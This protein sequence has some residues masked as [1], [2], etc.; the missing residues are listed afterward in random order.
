M[1][2][3]CILNQSITRTAYLMPQESKVSL[4]NVQKPMSK[5][6]ASVHLQGRHSRVSQNPTRHTKAHSGDVH[7]T[8]S[9]DW[10]KYLVFP[11][12]YLAYTNQ[13]VT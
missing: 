7:P 8:Q 12:D 1:E 10:C 4:R 13:Q 2:E 9:L 6:K 5:S 3:N 11:D